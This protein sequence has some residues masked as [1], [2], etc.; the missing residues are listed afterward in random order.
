[1]SIGDNIREIRL[2]KKMSQDQVAILMNKKKQWLSMVELG[3]RD[4]KLTEAITLAEIFDVSLD[5][6]INSQNSCSLSKKSYSL[7]LFDHISEFEEMYNNLN[8]RDKVICRTLIELAQRNLNL[9]NASFWV[10]SIC[11]KFIQYSYNELIRMGTNNISMDEYTGKLM[12]IL[13]DYAKTQE[14]V[15]TIKPI[16]RNR[17]AGV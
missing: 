7:S 5:A 2:K 11:Q 9:D 3:N 13:F 1:M 8:P 4:L 14:S 6:L 12:S 16:N 10:E 17:D 15:T